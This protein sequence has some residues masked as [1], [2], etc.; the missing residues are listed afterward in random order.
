MS[1]REFTGVFKASSTSY[2]PRSELFCIQ[3]GQWTSAFQHNANADMHPTSLEGIQLL[4]HG[5]IPCTPFNYRYT[6]IFNGQQPQHTVIMMCSS[7]T[8]TTFSFPKIEVSMH[9]HYIV[10][11][12]LPHPCHRNACTLHTHLV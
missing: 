7:N 1:L 8:P 4:S 5:E 9:W 11:L 12:L 2:A 10:S 6:F 3:C